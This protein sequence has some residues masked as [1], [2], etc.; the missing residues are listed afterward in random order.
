MPPH[1]SCRRI[2]IAL[3]F[4]L[5]LL[6]ACQ[7]GAATP[8][9]ATGGGAGT[10]FW[11]PWPLGYHPFALA[12]W[13]YDD[14]TIGQWYGLGFLWFLLRFVLAVLLGLLDL[15]LIVVLGVGVLLHSLLGVTARNVYFGFLALAVLLA[16]GASAYATRRIKG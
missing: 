14:S 1:R 8:A 15:V 4:A 7:A 2:T 11:Q 5:L 10:T 3:L 9:P 13:A 12:K 6:T 16:I